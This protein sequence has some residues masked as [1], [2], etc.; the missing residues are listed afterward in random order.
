MKLRLADVFD[1]IL[2]AELSQTAMADSGVLTIEN[3]NRVIT[4]INA[5]MAE[6]YKRFYLKRKE[7]QLQTCKGITRYTLDMA[8]ARQM[9]KLKGIRYIID[10][11]DPILDDLMEI[12]QIFNCN[13]GGEYPLNVD[14]GSV[15]V[16][17]SGG[18]YGCGTLDV[19]HG[20]TTRTPYGC[21]VGYYMPDVIYTPAY[22]IIRVP[23]CFAPTRLRVVYRA[24]GQRIKKVEDNGLYDPERIVIDL[25][26]SYLEP[27][28]YYIA[29][30]LLSA[31][32]NGV[33]QQFH[34]GN[35]YYSK[36]NSACAMLVDQGL[37]VDTIGGYDKLH[38][39]GFV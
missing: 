11:E 8:H 10:C 34:E 6:I 23:D 2:F 18:V 1:N 13:T 26:Y 32:M 19:P 15:P 5:G 37:D 33:D 20:V 39:K 7:L 22:N 29:S 36:F 21:R 4:I 38:G 24:S 30:R 27:L 25:P 28:V 16:R 17:G 9:E 3:A 12:V 31:N 14:T 35:N